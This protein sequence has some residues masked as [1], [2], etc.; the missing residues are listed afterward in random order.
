MNDHDAGKPFWKVP[1]MWLVVG[2][3]LAA[4]IAGV[5]LVVIAVR[6]GGADSVRDDV[7]RVSQ[8]QV[9]DLGPDE[10]ARRLRLSAVMRVDEGFVEV[11]PVTGT[12]QRGEPLQL[13]LQHPSSEAEDLEATLAPAANG[14]RGGIEPDPG[15]DWIVRLS[16]QDGSWRIHGRLPRGQRAVRLSPS[17]PQQRD[18]MP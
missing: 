3:P 15:H 14:W 9:A 5:S 8:I 18:G 12:F 2:L 11:I 6:S 17:L 1:A 10:Q 16:A 4:V 7:R 13:L